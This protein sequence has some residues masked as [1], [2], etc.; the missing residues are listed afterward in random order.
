MMA[1]EQGPLNQ[2]KAQQ[3]DVQNR[4]A[5]YQAI[6]TKVNTLQSSLHTLLLPSN[7]NAK[8]VASTFT[9]VAT[10]TASSGAANATYSLNVD[11]LAT[12][13][14][15]SSAT[16]DGTNWNTATIGAGLNPTAA[17]ESS[18]FAIAPTKGTFTINGK[19]IRIGDA[20]GN[21]TGQSLQDVIDAIN[22]TPGIDVTASITQDPATGKYDYISL[23]SNDGKPIQ[24]G[25]GDDTS[26]FLTA[27]RL[28][29]T[30]LASSGSVSADITSAA[31]LGGANTNA[32]LSDRGVF[33]TP[34]SGTGSFTVNGKTINW[35]ASKD[36]LSTVL[37]KINS[38]GAGV[39]AVYD[40]MTDSISMAN[41][42]TGNQTIAL[43]D[44]SGGL[45]SALH[46]GS[47]PAQ[48][49]LG[50]TAQFQVNG[51][52]WQ[53]SNSN[54][55]TN[56][57]PGVAIKLT[58][59]GSTTL[60]VTQD[61]ST[62][63]SNVQTFVSA[64]NDLVDSIDQATA[65]DAANNKASTLTGDSTMTGFEDQLRNLLANAVPGL[66]GQYTTLAGIGIST[67]A[68]GSA[69]GS[70][71]H[72]VVDTDK[73]TAALQADPNSVVSVIAGSPAATLN[74]DSMGAP[75]TSSWI[76]GISGT[77]LT[78]RH[79]QYRVTVDSL[80]NLSAVFTADGSTPL[81]P[82][83]GT[84]SAFGTNSTLIPGLTITAGAL[85][86]S[87]MTDTITYRSSG[88]LGM[89]N[90]YLTTQLGTGGVFDAE[91]TSANSELSSLSSQITNAN[92]LLAQRQQTL[93]QQ[94]TAMETAMA[95]IQSQNGSLL[96]SMGI[97]S[98]QSSS[99]SS[100]KSS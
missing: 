48:Q 14:T 90:D 82:L 13:T 60:S 8:A 36:T 87:S 70:T 63:I 58:G 91:H 28:V 73:L 84:I 25:A 3:T 46:L 64:F 39:T 76:T 12:A 83:T 78:T 44:T 42:A 97:S 75:G 98:S 96:S 17:I 69:A 20:N 16:F 77:P 81:A 7:V 72:L 93:Q 22:A 6:E 27:A 59:A 40:P 38:S 30:G 35:D 41:S 55:V 53:Y 94:F 29:A 47:D 15:V 74:P 66:S 34:L 95:Q 45:L 56:T 24:L 99:S 18:G 21:S 65:Y 49:T 67:G 68:Y 71:N 2:L 85:P 1:R 57:L 80:G 11:H 61:T 100:S 10:A 92:A 62:T 31:P 5:A 23:H 52:A 51:G 86:S 19:Q 33:G 37:G 79:G 26:N 43:S 50:K 88:I 32:L 54:T 9:T 89:L 4:D